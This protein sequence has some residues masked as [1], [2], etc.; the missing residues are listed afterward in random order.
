MLEGKQSLFEKS[1]AKTFLNLVHGQWPRQRPSSQKN[2]VMPAKAGIHDFLVSVTKALD[3]GAA[4]KSWMPAFAGVTGVR[5]GGGR[6][7]FIRDFNRIAYRSR[8]AAFSS[9]KEGLS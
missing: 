6:D 7:P 1:D 8:F 9:E 2:R 5:A 3:P 4:R